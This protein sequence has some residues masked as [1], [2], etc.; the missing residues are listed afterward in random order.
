MPEHHSVGGNWHGGPKGTC[1]RCGYVPPPP[2][3][4]EEVKLKAIPKQKLEVK[5]VVRKPRKKKVKDAD[6]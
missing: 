2:V 4:V 6:V 1:T 3:V 5:K